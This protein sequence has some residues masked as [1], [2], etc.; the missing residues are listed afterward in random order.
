[1]TSLVLAVV[2]NQLLIIDA[3]GQNVDLNADVATDKNE[4]LQ[5]TGQRVFEGIRLK[6]L[7]PLEGKTWV[8]DLTY[9]DYTSKKKTSIKSNVLITRSR[10]DQLVWTFDM[11]YPLE[12]G[13][14]SKEDVKLSADGKTFDGEMVVERINLPDGSLRIVTTKPGKDDNRDATFKHTYLIGKKSFSLRKDVK[15]DGVEEFFERNTYSW[16]R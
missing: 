8:G 4:F 11:Q 14:N 15:F 5:I 1:M 7:K 6:D 16:T 3:P 13:A 10:T 9:L 2:L 12:P